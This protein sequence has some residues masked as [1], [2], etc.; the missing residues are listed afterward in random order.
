MI[1][2]CRVD[3]PFLCGLVD[4]VTDTQFDL[5]Q[6]VA[7]RVANWVV[8][9]GVAAVGLLMFVVGTVTLSTYG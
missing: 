8:A 6:S 3:D 1:A 7:N 4:A 9:V 2:D 5:Y